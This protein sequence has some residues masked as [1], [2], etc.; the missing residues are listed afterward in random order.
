MPVPDKSR[1]IHR[2]PANKHDNTQNQIKSF[3]PFGRLC[4]A[5]LA[6]APDDALGLLRFARAPPG[7]QARAH[8]AAA[9]GHDGEE[10]QV[11]F[12]IVGVLVDSKPC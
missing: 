9:C 6:Q 3:D 11:G 10:D 5:W 2:S 8:I 4:R 12:D 7:D 1:I